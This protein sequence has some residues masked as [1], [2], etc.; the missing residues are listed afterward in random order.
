VKLCM[1]TSLHT[2][3]QKSSTARS[4]RIGPMGLLQLASIMYVIHRM[5]AK[6]LFYFVPVATRF[7]RLKY[8][9]V[10]KFCK[11]FVKKYRVRGF[12]GARPIKNGSFI[13]YYHEMKVLQMEHSAL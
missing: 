4:P 11:N 8:N 6:G 12:D 13:E 7:C 1:S 3:V 5:C 9:F 10:N 2:H